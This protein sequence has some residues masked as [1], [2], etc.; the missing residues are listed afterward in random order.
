MSTAFA[1]GR[2]LVVARRRAS[3][4]PESWLYAVSLAAWSALVIE[5]VQEAAHGSGLHHDTHA[6][7][8]GFGASVGAVGHLMLMVAAMM[9]PLMAPHTRAVVRRGLWVHRH[10]A[11]A[12][13]VVGYLVPWCAFNIGLQLIL[14]AAAPNASRPG[15]TVVLLLVAAAWQCTRARRSLWR[16]CCRLPPMAATGRRA[17]ADRF[18][19]G[20]R[21]GRLCIGTCGPV[22]AVMAVS[23]GIGTAAALSGVLLAEHRRGPNPAE[24]VGA[25]SQAAWLV[26][27]AGVIGLGV[28]IPAIAHL[29]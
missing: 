13:F 27:L 1:S 6:L 25:A 10:R 14:A 28:T 8:V 15:L 12:A 3:V 22:M 11:M 20:Q 23:H 26:V 4:R 19:A 24:R 5:A 17:N 29:A 21:L 7:R 9:L 18:L 2:A 16:R